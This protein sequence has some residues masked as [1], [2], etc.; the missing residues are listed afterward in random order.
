[1]NDEKITPYFMSL[2][3]QNTTDALLSDIRN[4]NG[5]DFISCSE[6]ER[7]ITDYYSELYRNKD[8]PTATNM[9]ID[10]F[11][12]DVALH[13]DV[14]SSRLTDGEKADFGSTIEPHFINIPLTAM[15]PG[16]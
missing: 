9:T 3:K 12:G 1:L 7:Y 15:R 14:V 13:P 5:N 2:A 6:R 10:E 4:D 8:N 16:H 11:L